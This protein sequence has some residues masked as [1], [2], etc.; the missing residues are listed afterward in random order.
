MLSTE[1]ALALA[2]ALHLLVCLALLALSCRRMLMAA[3]SCVAMAAFV[4]AFGPIAVALLERRL[5]KGGA[6]TQDLGI[7]ELRVQDA[8]HRSIPMEQSAVGDA[9]VPLGEALRIN[10]PL[11]RRALIMDVLYDGAE[12]LP[13]ALREAR[14]NDDAEVVHY[15]TTALVELQKTYDA[16]TAQA[17]AA[18]Q[19]DPHDPEAA[20]RLADV[21]GDYIASGLLEG[22]MLVSLRREYDR[23]L[24]S[25]LACVPQGSQAALAASVHAFD[26]ARALQD[27]STMREMAEACVRTWPRREEGHLMALGCAVAQRDR[28]AVDAALAQLRSPDVR[29]SLRGRAEAVYWE[30]RPEGQDRAARPRGGDPD[31]A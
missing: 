5:R 29:L 23:A 7:E 17:R 26:N 18:Q 27:A 2:L 31:A 3:P 9:V 19:A 13:G 1:L 10:D 14:G 22:G 11:T 24:R 15:A 8:V 4:P 6:C 20:Q 21:L 25:L 16:R 12:G 30:A 28:A